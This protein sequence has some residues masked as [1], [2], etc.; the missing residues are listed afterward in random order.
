MLRESSHPIRRLSLLGRV[1]AWVLLAVIV[2]VGVLVAAAFWSSDADVTWSGVVSVAVGLGLGA[3]VAW[4]AVTGRALPV[5][6]FDLGPEDE[7]VVKVHY[8][9]D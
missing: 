8:K 1:L 5:F 2:S 4:S 7:V 3:V 9:A 6:P